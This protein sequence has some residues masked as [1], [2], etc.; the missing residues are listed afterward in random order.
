MSYDLAVWEGERP[1]DDAEAANTFGRLYSE[2]IDSGDEVAPSERIQ[3]F[4]EALVDRYPNIGEADED[5]EGGPWSDG[6]LIDNA[7]G[8]LVYFGMVWSRAEAV[9]QWAADLAAEH[10][11]NCFDPQ[12]NRLRTDLREGWRFELQSER[13][14]R[15]HDPDQDSV[16]RVISKL[17]RE[18][19]YAVLERADGWYIQVGL[20]EKASARAGWYALERR[21]GSPDHHYRVELSDV[22]TVCSAFVA[23][24]DGDESLL[25]RFGWRPYT[26]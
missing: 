8:P 4:V 3:A 21:D 13:G 25:T 5:P 9:S 2:Y 15:L 1:A 23:F 17:S 20:G 11:L 6:P 19:Y 26:V 18:N 24:M 7:S 16:R 12:W 10:G 22:E 14:Q